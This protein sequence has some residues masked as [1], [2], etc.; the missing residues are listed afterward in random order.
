MDS[1]TL[2]INRIDIIIITVGLKHKLPVSAEHPL[3]EVFACL[4]VNRNLVKSS[5]CAAVNI[6]CLNYMH[7]ENIIWCCVQ[8]LAAGPFVRTVL[9]LT[10]V[11][12]QSE[13][14]N[15]MRNWLPGTLAMGKTDTP[16]VS[17]FH[18]N[19]LSLRGCQSQAS[20]TMAVH[21]QG[22]LGGWILWS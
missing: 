11:W 21:L 8:P 3:S 19:P 9:I 22:S 10:G 6:N 2:Q 7:K 14:V 5:S 15:D 20:G 1:F 12:R 16:L 13:M 4:L 18:L 17:R